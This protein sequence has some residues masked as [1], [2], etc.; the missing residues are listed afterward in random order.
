MFVIVSLQEDSLGLH[1]MILPRVVY[2]NGSVLEDDMSVPRPAICRSLLFRVLLMSLR[3]ALNCLS[4]VISLWPRTLGIVL[5][6][7]HRYTTRMALTESACEKR[8]LN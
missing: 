7:T 5:S 2:S 4:Y 1:W 3:E 8:F 6:V